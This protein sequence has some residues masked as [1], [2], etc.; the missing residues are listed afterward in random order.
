MQFTR[1]SHSLLLLEL[2]FCKKDPG[3]IF[4]FA[5]SSLG[6]GQRCCSP[7]LGELAGVLG[8]ERTGEGRGVAKGSVCR[9][10]RGGG[11]SGGGVRRQPGAESASWPL[12]VLVI[13]TSTI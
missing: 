1:I 9:V 4:T 6:R 11:G 5:M 8:R 12:I 3:K 13:M 10:G 7:E 2:H